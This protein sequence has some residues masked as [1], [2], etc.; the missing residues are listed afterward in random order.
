MVYCSSFSK[1]GKRKKRT[2]CISFP[3]K[4]LRMRYS[5]CGRQGAE[6]ETGIMGAWN[7][8]GGARGA[9]QLLGKVHSGSERICG[10]SKT[11]HKRGGGLK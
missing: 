3:L 11:K 2:G 9:I 10:H 1:L 6:L 7:H 8:M 4:R 5:V